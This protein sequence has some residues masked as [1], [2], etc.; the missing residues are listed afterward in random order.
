MSGT[1]LSGQVAVQDPQN[2][3]VQEFYA[4]PDY[5]VVAAFVLGWV[6][7]NS[8]Y[9]TACSTLLREAIRRCCRTCRFHRPDQRSIDIEAPGADEKHSVN[10]RLGQSSSVRDDTDSGAFIFIL[11]ICFAFAAFAQFCSL[12]DLGG[13]DGNT[14]ACTFVIAWASMASH[15]ARMSGLLM[16]SREMG[17]LGIRRWETYLIWAGLLSVLG[18]VF[19]LNAIGTGN[20]SLVGPSGN[21]ICY[22]QYFLPLS[23]SLSAGLMSLELF[24]TL[25]LISLNSPTSRLRDVVVGALNLNVT[26]ALSLLVLDVMVV[27]P[28][29]I[30]VNMLAQYIPY[31]VGSILVL[32]TFNHTKRTHASHWNHAAVEDKP[33]ICIQRISRQT[34]NSLLTPSPILVNVLDEPLSPISRNETTATQGSHNTHNAE[35]TSG[36]SQVLLVSRMGLAGTLAG[37]AEDI[38]PLPLSAPPV[39]DGPHKTMALD[40]RKILPFQVEYAERLEQAEKEEQQRLAALPTGPVVRPPRQRPQVFVVIND[41]DRPAR[42][43]TSRSSVLGSDIIHLTHSTPR[44]DRRE[45]GIWSPDSAAMSS[46]RYASPHDSIA[47]S[48]PA[49]HGSMSAYSAYTSLRRSLS[50]EM[51]PERSERHLSLGD[52]TMSAGDVSRRYSWRPM[53]RLSNMSTRTQAWEELPTVV[54]GKPENSPSLPLTPSSARI[55]S[56]RRTFGQSWKGKPQYSKSRES[57]AAISVPPPSLRL[58]PS[59]H[60]AIPPLPASP[61]PALS[62]LPTLPASPYGAGRGAGMLGTIRGPRPPPIAVPSPGIS[63]SRTTMSTPSV[64]TARKQSDEESMSTISS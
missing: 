18:L 10:V 29:A 9:Y 15:C 60:A 46:Y 22:R 36:G 53:A 3:S 30:W 11:N 58:T 2:P 38:L 1:N 5:R 61:L 34:L 8:V 48:R 40:P 21:S 33:A 16:L 32:V 13:S 14:I 43:R 64:R 17:R 42:S 12:L 27:V 24:C 26:R 4:H 35:G 41:E 56:K 7:L 31:S 63:G 6:F 39:M 52:S 44:K 37:A 45:S 49:V 55:R 20:T 25:R 59:P 62:P 28:A 54:E 50:T 23:L 51:S 47:A 19:A 57:L